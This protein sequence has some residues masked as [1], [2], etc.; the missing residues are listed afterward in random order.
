[1]SLP[2]MRREEANRDAEMMNEIFRSRALANGAR[3]ID[4]FQSFATADNG[5]DAYGPD[6]AGK[7]RLIREPDGVHFTWHGSLKLAHFVE[8]EIKRAAQ[9]AW[10]ERTI[11]LAGSEAEQ[12]RIRPL[13]TVKV[14]PPGTVPASTRAGR[15]PARIAS[16]AAGPNSPTTADS[17]A[18]GIAAQSS[19]IVLK[20]INAQGREETVKLEIV[21][22]AIPPTVLALIKR[23]ESEDKASQIGDAVMTEI[24]GSMT[25]VSSVTPVAEVASDR[26]RNASLVYSPLSRVLQRGETLP[27]KPGRADEMPWPRPEPVVAKVTYMPLVPGQKR[28]ATTPR[29]PE[30][31]WPGGPSLPRRP[32]WA[33]NSR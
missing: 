15:S 22:P 27:P 6:L 28:K 30:E 16:K 7:N 26:R 11:P 9:D 1:V 19:E 29:A 23:R 31:A 17:A 14:A 4:I 3:Y 21:R 10:D 18:G 12:A 5:Y 20:S 25:V 32:S 8:K 24:L 13:S 33:G 2:I